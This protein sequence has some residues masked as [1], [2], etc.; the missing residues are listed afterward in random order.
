[1]TTV[2]LTKEQA[3]WV[4]GAAA[5][6]PDVR[7]DIVNTIEEVFCREQGGCKKHQKNQCSGCTSGDAV[8]IKES[9]PFPGVQGQVDDDLLRRRIIDI[10]NTHLRKAREIT[11]L[12]DEEA[13]TERER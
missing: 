9:L 4:W 6:G 3:A 8:Y 10:R 7:P 11:F 2:D 13:K 5:F 1:M 12:L